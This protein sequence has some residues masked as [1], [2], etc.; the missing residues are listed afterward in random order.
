MNP[1][2]PPPTISSVPSSGVSEIVYLADANGVIRFA[3]P[4]AAH[5]Y[6]YDLSDLIGQAALRYVLPAERE[7]VR[8]WWQQFVNAPDR[9][10]AETRV[11]FV[12]A[13]G[14]PVRVRVSLWRLPTGDDF[15]AVHH[16][17]DQLRD[18]METLYAILT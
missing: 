17:F 12:R 5:M 16:V 13:D 6:G 15:L 10:S 4:P 3:T 1:A 8:D 11:T 7:T 9:R 2:V 14:Q 18:R